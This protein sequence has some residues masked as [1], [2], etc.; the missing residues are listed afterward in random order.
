LASHPPCTP[1]CDRERPSRDAVPIDQGHHAASVS[2]RA[3]PLRRRSRVLRAIAGIAC[4]AQRLPHPT[5]CASVGP[6]AHARGMVLRGG[7]AA[8]RDG[9]SRSRHG[10]SWRAGHVSRWPSAS[11]TSEPTP[12]SCFG[13]RSKCSPHQATH[14]AAPSIGSA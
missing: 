1:H 12:T 4:K 9:L 8:Y 10:A 13:S 3:N 11:R 5:R 6:L 14:G 7:W 2:E